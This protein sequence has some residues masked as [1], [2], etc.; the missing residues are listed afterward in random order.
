MHLKVKDTV[1]VLSGK[2]RGRRGAVLSLSPTKGR[3]V[4]EGVNMIK[5]HVRA[6]PRRGIKGGILQREAAVHVSTLMVVC[7]RCGAPTRVGCERLADGRPARRC[8][9]PACGQHLDN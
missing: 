1:L 5:K 9:R 4:V 3:A 2:D 7:P 6:N 8:K